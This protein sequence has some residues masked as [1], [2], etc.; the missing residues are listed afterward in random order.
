MKKEKNMLLIF[1][2]IIKIIIKN[3]IKNIII[4]IKII[5]IIKNMKEKEVE[6]KI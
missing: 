4:E 1:K 3:I 5:I 6:K 2:K